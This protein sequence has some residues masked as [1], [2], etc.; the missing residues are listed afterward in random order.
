[1]QEEHPFVD[2]IHDFKKVKKEDRAAELRRINDTPQGQ[3]K[4]PEFKES[5]PNQGKWTYN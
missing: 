4:C 5:Y 1:M 3:G 2:H